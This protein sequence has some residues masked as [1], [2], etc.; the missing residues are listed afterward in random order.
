MVEFAGSAGHDRPR[1]IDSAMTGGAVARR[2]D[3][4]VPPR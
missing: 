2:P 1:V 4:S 3:A